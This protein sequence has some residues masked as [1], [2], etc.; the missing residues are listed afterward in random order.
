MRKMA[1]NTDLLKDTLAYILMNPEK[2]DQTHWATKV[3]GT[4]T[5]AYCFAGTAVHLQ[6]PN[7]KMVGG[8]P[9]GLNHNTMAFDVMEVPGLGDVD[10][11]DQAAEDLGLSEDQVACLFEAA[12]TLPQILRM[13]AELLEDPDADLE[14]FSAYES[15]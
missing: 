2:W 13:V 8:W 5:T 10:I 1:L 11:E 7:S 3:K 15:F 9:I 12:N 14:E 4:C 6:H